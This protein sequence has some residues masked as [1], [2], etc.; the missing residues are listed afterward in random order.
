MGATAILEYELNDQT[1]SNLFRVRQPTTV[2]LDQNLKI[3]C[4]D[5]TEVQNVFFVQ[6]SISTQASKI[7]LQVSSIDNTAVFGISNFEIH[8]GSCN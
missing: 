6:H 1:G 7:I 3:L 4:K 2:L 5:D 8:Y